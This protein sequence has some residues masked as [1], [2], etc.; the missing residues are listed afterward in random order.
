VPSASV[1]AEARFNTEEDR[2]A[3]FTEYVQAAT[4]LLEQYGNKE[5]APYRVVLAAY[6]DTEDEHDAQDEPHPTGPDQEGA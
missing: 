2:E 3:F 4:R 6:P 5:G 1:V